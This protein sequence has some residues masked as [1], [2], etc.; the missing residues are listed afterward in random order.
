[1]IIFDN[2]KPS[3]EPGTYKIKVSQE[4]NISNNTLNISSADID[5]KV[6]GEKYRIDQ[7][8]IDSVFPPAA[9]VGDFS[10]IFPQ[11]VLNRSTLPWERRAQETDPG[12]PWLALILITEDDIKDFNEDPNRSFVFHIKK[13]DWEGNTTEITFK[14]A[15]STPDKKDE[16]ISVLAAPLRFFDDRIPAFTEITYLCHVRQDNDEK[17]VVICNKL[18][19][20]DKKNII[21]LVSLEN[22]FVN[23]KFVAKKDSTGKVAIVT[24][25]S[26]EFFCNDHFILTKEIIEHSGLGDDMKKVLNAMV[27]SEYFNHTD[28]ID[29]IQKSSLSLNITLS[30]DAA[31]QKSIAD[32]FRIGHLPEILKHLNRNPGSL[33]PAHNDEHSKQGY[34]PLKYTFKTGKQIDAIYRGPLTP[35][36]NKVGETAITHSDEALQYFTDAQK[37]DI[38]YAAAW[39]LGKLLALHNKNFS[40]ALYK[41]KRSCYQALKTDQVNFTDK[42]CPVPPIVRSWFN[43]QQ[44]FSGIVN[45]LKLIPFNYLVPDPSLIPFESIRFFKIDPYWLKYLVDGAFSI[46][47]KSKAELEYDKILYSKF[48]FLTVPV[49]PKSGFLLHSVAVNGWP[50]MIVYSEREFITPYRKDRLSQNLLFCLFTGDINSVSIYQKLQSIHFGLEHSS[51]FISIS[52]ILNGNNIKN[53]H[54]PENPED[55]DV[56]DFVTLIFQDSSVVTFNISQ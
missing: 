55:G 1:M 49:L 45:D 52:N 29:A 26:W 51:D 44:N 24:L 18:P 27:G 12:K 30:L 53:K 16:L 21:H 23:G 2:H 22:C 4:V 8:Q 32:T 38:S 17:A 46:A 37:L 6:E 5:F 13:T 3:L 31:V 42:T 14:E 15:V 9:S 43:D 28:F 47:R 40:V 20:K 50:D 56:S 34:I 11:I 39:E 54:Y 25:K 36:I 19:K 48:N 41:W 35:V 33:V 7:L 10:S